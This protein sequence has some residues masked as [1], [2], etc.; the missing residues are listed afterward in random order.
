MLWC[1]Y[2]QLIVHACRFV[3]VIL[4]RFHTLARSGGFSPK[5]ATYELCEL[6][7][8]R[9][10]RQQ[11]EMSVS[12]EDLMDQLK[13]YER[14]VSACQVLVNIVLNGTGMQIYFYLPFF[15]FIIFLRPSNIGVMWWCDVEG[16]FLAIQISQFWLLAIWCYC[17]GAHK[18]YA[19][20]CS[21]SVQVDHTPSSI[22]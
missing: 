18:W 3:L 19:L 4:G 20:Q 14:D 17:I 15:W 2:Q 9:R 10:V 16:V 7:E 6:D 12:D 21:D 8:Y 22:I 5:L 11:R 13:D 1:S